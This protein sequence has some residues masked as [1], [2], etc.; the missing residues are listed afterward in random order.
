MQLSIS[1]RSSP[2]SKA[3]V[4]EVL[5]ELQH[6]HPEVS[7]QPVYVKTVGDLDRVTSL[8]TLGKTDFFTREVD[9]KVLSGECRVAVHSAKDLPEPLPAGLEIVALTR[10]LDPSDALV[11]RAGES[12]QKGAV[13][14]TSSLRREEMVRELER[15]VRFVDIRGTIEERLARMDAGAVDGVVIAEAALIRLGLTHLNRI[16]LPGETTP[17]QG[18]LAILARVGDLEMRELFKSLHHQQH[19]LFSV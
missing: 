5:V 13:I 17:L 10:G 4:Q 7:F 9:G 18:R 8:R 12:L 1:A 19:E 14:A 3:Q 6:M 16:R 2:L 11:L 15:D